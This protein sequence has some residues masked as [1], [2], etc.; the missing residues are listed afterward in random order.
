LAA[1]GIVEHL[2][3]S[4][5]AAVVGIVL[6]V[7]LVDIGSLVFRLQVELVVLLA[8][9]GWAFLGCLAIVALLAAAALLFTN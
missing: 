8:L 7:V 6:L 9:V 3:A 2:L 4:S 5:L 1:V